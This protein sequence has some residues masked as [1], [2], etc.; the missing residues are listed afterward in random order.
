MKY[1]AYKYSN[2]DCVLK[3]KIFVK[4]KNACQF[5]ILGTLVGLTIIVKREFIFSMAREKLKSRF[6]CRTFS[7]SDNSEKLGH[8]VFCNNMYL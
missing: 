4:I 5:H 6:I 1:A 7:P 3:L 2:T 8:K